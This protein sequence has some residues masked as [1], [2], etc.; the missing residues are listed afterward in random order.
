M[1][2]VKYSPREEVIIHEIIQYESPEEMVNYLTHGLPGPYP[3]LQWVEGLL[4]SFSAL[5]HTNEVSKE[6]IKGKLHWDSCFVAPLEEFQNSININNGMIT[7]NVLD[8]SHN[9][10]F[11]A[12]GKA[13]KEEI[14]PSLNDTQ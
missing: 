12:I 5:P 14:L 2:N 4:L 7:V 1:T 11:Q 6:I 8:V 13:L 3:A 10:T 9:P